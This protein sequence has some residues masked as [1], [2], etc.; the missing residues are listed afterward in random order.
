MVRG[1]AVI[2]VGQVAA[3]A[4]SLGLLGCSTPR[5]AG[6]VRAEANEAYSQGEYETALS[7]FEELKRRDPHSARIRMEISRTLLAM[8]RANE[9]A[10]EAEVALRLE[11]DND[12][13]A[14]HYARAMADAGHEQELFTFLERRA[15]ESGDPG[16]YVRLGRFLADSGRADEAHAA[17]LR[18]AELDRGQSVEPQLALAEFYRA[19]GDEAREAE[20]LR[21][22]LY[23]DER[24]RLARERLIGLGYD[25]SASLATAPPEAID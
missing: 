6:V 14:Q 13:Y 9:A 4:G 2:R 21:A 1:R 5:L 15:L 23:L 20:R 10:A 25:P 24:N 18:A 16:E 17:L 19:I 11:P 3:I 8:G 22:A 7:L 12:E